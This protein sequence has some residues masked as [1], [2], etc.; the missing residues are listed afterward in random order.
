MYAW[1]S[2]LTPEQLEQLEADQRAAWHQAR[3]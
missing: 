2:V 1:K 3:F